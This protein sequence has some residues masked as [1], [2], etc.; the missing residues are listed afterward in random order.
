MRAT[1][2][3]GSRSSAAA[4][5]TVGAVASKAIA[6]AKGPLHALRGTGEEEKLLKNAKT[7]YP[8]EHEEIATYTAI[9]TFA[10]SVGDK[11]TA[12]LARSIRRDEERMAG[13][14]ERLIP[15]LA[16]AVARA[17]VPAAQR[18]NGRRRPTAPHSARKSGPRARGNRRRSSPAR[19]AGRRRAGARERA[20]AAAR[21]APRRSTTGR[22]PASTTRR[23]MPRACPAVYAPCSRSW[24]PT[25]GR[26]AAGVEERTRRDGVTFGAAEDGLLALDPVP[27]LIDAGGVASGSSRGITQRAE[28]SS[29]SSTTSTASAKSS[30]PRG[31]RARH[32]ELRPL[33][34]RDARRTPARAL[35]LGRSASTSFAEPTGACACSRTRSGC[36]RGSPMRRPRARSSPT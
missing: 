10:D 28:R 20:R 29:A 19:V 9:E 35:D 31:P 6:T 13:Y 18:S 12:K 5:T 34:A 27:R 30:P 17:E 36:R 26:L 3:A 15:Q 2:S 32:L 23:S 16:K 7:E 1:S 22:S 24:P 25:R 14:L 21:G 11:E 4:P 33:R 8:E